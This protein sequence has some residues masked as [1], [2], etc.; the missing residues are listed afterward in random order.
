MGMGVTERIARFAVDS[1]FGDI[2]ADVCRQ[3]KMGILDWL[4]AFIAALKPESESIKIML[5]LLSELGG[6]PKATIIGLKIRTSTP[7]ASLVN[8]YI[9]HLLDYDET[10]TAVRSHLTAAILPAVLAV[11]EE[12]RASGRKVLE[13]YVL[14]YEV[15]L[16]VGEVMT[17]G[18]M[19]EGW[20]GTSIFGVF[21]ATAGCGKILEL[22]AERM[23][24]AIGMAASMAS[25]IAGNFGTMTKPL[26][27]GLAA[28][29]GVLAAL[30]AKRGLTAAKDA[31][32]GP[33]GFFHTYGWAEK[34]KL[35]RIAKLG[36][37]WGLETPGMMNPK[38]YPCCHGLATSIEHGILIRDRYRISFEDVEEIEIHSQPKTL[39]AMLSKRYVGTSEPVMW[40]YD[41]PPRQITPA[42]PTTGKEAKFSK[43][44][45][46]A[47]AIQDGK[48]GIAHF[49]DEAVRDPL[50]HRWMEKIKVYH[51]S[52]LEKISN[53]HPEEEWPYGERVV[54]KLKDGRVI[55]EEEIF[56]Q[57]AVKRPLSVEHVKRKF[58][59]CASEAGL[60]EQRRAKI[61]SMIEDLQDVG[62][63]S[64]R[65]TQLEDLV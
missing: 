54:I 40:G 42:I 64:K 13:S 7:L 46:F 31:L 41:G 65:I 38:L 53:T 16:R 18:W 23:W 1:D 35:E 39:S 29:S 48:V 37:P 21:G 58:Y 60:S 55:E 19:E 49:T 43:E 56:V 30:L 14:G 15:S 4:A 36:N 51:N 63:I 10:C 45:A 3:A 22:D 59:E 61:V 26:H 33:L 52:R 32:E 28:K 44:Y 27:A 47:R 6:Q 8:G 50:I 2:P 12:S 57:G 11:G 34:P 25:G 9:G 20:H 5:D 24:N 17:P 62:D